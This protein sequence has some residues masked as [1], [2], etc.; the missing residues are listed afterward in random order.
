[1]KP[2][3]GFQSPRPL[4]HFL[5]LMSRGVLLKRNTYSRTQL[6]EKWFSQRYAQLVIK[7]FL[8][9][10]LWL[11]MFLIRQFFSFSNIV[12]NR[13]T[14]L[15]TLPQAV[16]IK[17]L[18]K[19]RCSPIMPSLMKKEEVSEFEVMWS[20]LKGETMTENQA[21]KLDMVTGI[22]NPCCSETEKKK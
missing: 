15:I 22:F 11:S 17:I 16:T 6:P 3:P 1:M 4:H 8:V 19:F 2:Q 9:N 21:N 12:H 10:K 14:L 18:G 7:G 5:H 20:G 13:L